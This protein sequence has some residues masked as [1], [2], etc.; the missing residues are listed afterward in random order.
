MDEMRHFGRSKLSGAKSA[1]LFMKQSCGKSSSDLVHR[2]HCLLVQIGGATM[3]ALQ[4]AVF[5]SLIGGSMLALSVPCY[6]AFHGR[7]FNHGPLASDIR[8]ERN[9]LQ[10][11]REKFHDDRMDLGQDKGTLRE[12]R[13]DGAS[14]AER[15]ID[16]SDIRQDH[17]DIAQDRRD[18]RGERRDLRHDFKEDRH[19][20]FDWWHSW[21]NR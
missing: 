19:S 16:R 6:A 12:D 9:A 15:A 21:W 3:K 8:S 2:L 17:R 14:R 1:G 4:I 13:H 20:F 5:G 18:L 7:S 10:Q 11:D